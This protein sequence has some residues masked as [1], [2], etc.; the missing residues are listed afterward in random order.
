[1][2]PSCRPYVPDNTLD[3]LDHPPRISS[4]ECLFEDRFYKKDTVWVSSKNPCK[5]CFCQNGFSKCDLMTCPELN[6]PNETRTV[7]G[8]CCPVCGT[9]ELLNVSKTCLLNG[10]PHSPGSKFHPFLIPNG[11]DLCTECICDP[12]DLE[13]KCSRLNDNEKSCSR[14]KTP[15][16]V[17]DLLI[18]DDSVDIPTIPKEEV[19]PSPELILKEGGC[20]NL[21]NRNKPHINGS[22]Y[23]PFIDSL[24]EYKCVTCKCLVS[25]RKYDYSLYR[26]IEN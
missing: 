21:H 5:M 10:I 7:S 8:E 23:H 20:T 17:N 18:E 3:L 15:N 25:T 4:G 9:K 19:H 1:M 16:N 11:F 6:C 24:G 22:S 2:P 14:Y 13:I 26:I 12:V